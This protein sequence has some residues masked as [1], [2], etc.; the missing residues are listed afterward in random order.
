MPFLLSNSLRLR[1][2]PG[3][4]EVRRAL[5]QAEQ[6]EGTRCSAHTRLLFREGCQQ[7]EEGGKV[8][9]VIKSCTM[10]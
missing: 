2:Q 10:P 8:D 1:G 9:I 4:A 7:G 3:A 6:E 5:G